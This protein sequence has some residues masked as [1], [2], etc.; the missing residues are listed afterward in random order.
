MAAEYNRSAQLRELLSVWA[1]EPPPE[2]EPE[3]EPA[4]TG[5]PKPSFFARV[6]FQPPSLG[7]IAGYL[8]DS[9]KPYG[10]REGGLT[11]GW[12][13]DLEGEGDYR[14]RQNLGTLAST[15]IV[16]DRDGSCA[17]ENWNLAVPNG[18][19]HVSVAF[20]DLDYTGSMSG[21]SV[22]GQQLGGEGAVAPFAG[23]MF[24]Y[25]EWDRSGPPH[26]S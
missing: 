9:G 25:C 15:L 1:L 13:C 10:L 8:R 7:A 24:H 21:C 16:P 22:E 5:P 2:P 19:Y 11:Y 6:N 4:P 17:S 3:P 18:L 20:G 26:L 12:D 23:V 14:D